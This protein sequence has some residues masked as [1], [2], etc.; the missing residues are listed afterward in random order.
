MPIKMIRKSTSQLSDRLFKKLKTLGS[1]WFAIGL[2]L[3]LLVACGTIKIDSFETASKAIQND[4][5]PKIKIE[6]ALVSDAAAA[7]YSTDSIKE[8]LPKIEDFPLY[9]AQPA[10][11]N[12]LASRRTRSR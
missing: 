4:F 7:R 9:G 11:Y 2:S 3:T 6:Q 12:S 10:V 1:L 5:L 8:P